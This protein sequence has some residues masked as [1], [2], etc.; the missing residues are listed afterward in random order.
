M[1]QGTFVRRSLAVATAAALAATMAAIQPASAADAPADAG[2]VTGVVVDAAGNPVVGDLVNSVGPREVP[3]HGIVAD[4]T[5]RRDF[6]D[7]NGRF[8]VRQASPNGYLIQICQPEPSYPKACKETAQGVDHVITYVGPTG[9]TDSWVLQTALFGTAAQDRD[10]GRVTVKPQS[11]VHGTIQGAANQSIRLLR[12]NG[13]VAFYGFTDEQGG[14]RFQGLAPG[15]YRIGAGGEGWLPWRSPIVSLAPGEDAQVDGAVSRGATIEGTVTSAGKPV[16]FTDI[17]V[18]T[19]AGKIVAAATTDARGVYRAS[20]LRPG[21]YQVGITYFGSDF[22]RKSVPVSV[23]APHQQVS[24]PIT[25]VR[26]AVVTLALRTDGHAALRADDELRNA[27]GR[28]IMGQRNLDGRVTY[29]GLA[30][31]RYTVVAGNDTNYAVAHV[32]V[33]RHQT[34]D[35]GTRVL[36]KPTL[37]LRGT[38]APR[39][40]VEATT[41]DMCPPGGRVRVGS[42]HEIER[43]DATG[44]YVLTGLVPGRYMLGSDAYPGNYAPYCRSGVAIHTDKQVDLPL[45]PGG[46]VT[47]RMVY[48]SNG[49]PLITQLSY[50]LTYPA[51]SPTNPTDEHPARD[52]AF[53]ASG[54][55][56]IDRL[57]AGRVTGTLAEGANLDQI[58]SP[59]FFVIYPFEDGTPYFLTSR[60]RTIDMAAGEQVRLGPVPLILHR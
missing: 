10:L 57:A 4:R 53:G 36:Q 15:R 14:Y 23:T 51:G 20:G 24:A 42:F 11:F 26:G 32:D 34:Y 49:K 25:L 54:L 47:G 21:D 12:L 3:E 37:I 8:R 30:P 29:P 55:F 40:V 33:T 59:K 6:T 16:T 50:E 58:T 27:K 17:L 39:A 22:V 46:V 2:W 31:G 44:H 48:A 43:A 35:L 45:K 60:P 1:S 5:D 7:D 18:R 56:R 28:P 41:G 9:V 19:S 13:T 52:R 38:T